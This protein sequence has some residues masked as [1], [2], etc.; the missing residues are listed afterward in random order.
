M[1]EIVSNQLRSGWM[2]LVDVYSAAD[3]LIMPVTSGGWKPKLTSIEE[4]LA[5]TRG[6]VT[7]LSIEDG[8]VTSIDISIGTAGV[9]R[10]LYGAHSHWDRPRPVRN[11]CMTGHTSATLLAVFD[12]I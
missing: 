7:D 5:T 2:G 8:V 4:S 1:T 10:R 6:S 3:F 11:L 9:K 12:R